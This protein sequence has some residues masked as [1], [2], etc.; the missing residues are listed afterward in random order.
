[1]YQI[2]DVNEE[3]LESYQGYLAEDLAE[4]I[5]R[6]Y[7][8][9]L[10]ATDESDGSPVSGM[11]WMLK[12]VEKD[13]DNES[14]IIWVRCDDKEAFNSMIK[15]YGERAKAE[16][17]VR[18][19]AFIPV[20]DG[21]EMKALL[22][23]NGFNMRLSESNVIL[24]KLSELIEMPM[25]KRMEKMTIPENIVPLNQLTMRTFRKGVARSV[26]QGR[27]GLCDDLSELGILWFE[28]DVSC[29]ST[30]DS[31]INGFFLFHKRPSGVLAVQLLICL[32]KSFKTT[33]PYMMRRFVTAMQE[34]YDPDTLVELDRHNEQALLLTEKL[35]PRGFGIPIYAGSRNE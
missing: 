29:V 27:Y 30:V 3:N 2:I 7:Y 26:S 32:D 9:G 11:V 12:N 5:G 4:N 14:E 28:D 17:V 21:K 35:L 6:T 8:R 23:E 13:A 16:G 22:I 31:A 24:V 20:K 1:M 10:V 15:E 33:L 18:S 25:M 19:T 34:K